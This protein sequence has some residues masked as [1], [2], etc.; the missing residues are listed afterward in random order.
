MRVGSKLIDMC[1]LLIPCYALLVGHQQRGLGLS[2]NWN[3]R[4]LLWENFCGRC[5]KSLGEAAPS[6]GGIPY[7]QTKRMFV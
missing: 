4:T 3:Q 7:C 2:V 5:W 1:V 6:L